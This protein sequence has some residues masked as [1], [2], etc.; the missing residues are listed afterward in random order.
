MYVKSCTKVKQHKQRDTTLIKV[1]TISSRSITTLTRT[2]LG[3][4]GDAGGSTVASWQEIAAAEA[5]HVRSLH[6]LH[7]PG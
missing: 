1:Q 2:V 3:Q 5:L 4:H 7:V 6:N